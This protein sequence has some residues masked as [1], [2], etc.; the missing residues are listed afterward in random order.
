MEIISFIIHENLCCLVI[1]TIQNNRAPKVGCNAVIRN[2]KN[3]KDHYISRPL[4]PEE[5]LFIILYIHRIRREKNKWIDHNKSHIGI[6]HRME[7]FY[8]VLV[9]NQDK[10]F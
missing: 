5:H 3:S 10:P 8:R 9:V 7:P 1:S 2:T 6:I 4:N